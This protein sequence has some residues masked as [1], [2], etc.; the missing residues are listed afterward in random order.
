MQFLSQ[1]LFRSVENNPPKVPINVVVVG[2][3]W[4]QEVDFSSGPE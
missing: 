4:F 1:N 2:G 3:T